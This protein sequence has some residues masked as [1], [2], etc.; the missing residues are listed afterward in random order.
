M[1]VWN[2]SGQINFHFL[3]D[4][5]AAVNM[6]AAKEW[7]PKLQNM[8]SEYP[9]EHGLSNCDTRTTT[10]TPNIVYWYTA[11]I[12]NRNIKKDNNLKKINTT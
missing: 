1:G 2:R 8:S 7:K 3:S 5:E 10:G 6:E 9:L 12:K 4:E 11:L